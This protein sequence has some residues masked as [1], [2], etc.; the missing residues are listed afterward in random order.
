MTSAPLAAAVPPHSVM[1]PHPGIGHLKPM[2][3]VNCAAPAKL[4]L[5]TPR[6]QSL[7]DAGSVT[8]HPFVDYRNIQVS[9]T[10]GTALSPR[11]VV[12]LSFTY[13]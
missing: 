13:S 10:S 7:S 12:S 5:S 8:V 3:I 2:D 9:E 4:H 1:R 6:F 11:S